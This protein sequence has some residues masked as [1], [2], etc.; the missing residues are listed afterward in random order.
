MKGIVSWKHSLHILWNVPIKTL[1]NNLMRL[2]REC[3]LKLC[4]RFV[5]SWVDPRLLICSLWKL[6]PCVTLFFSFCS[7]SVWQVFVARQM[8]EE[9]NETSQ[10]HV[11]KTKTPVH[12][13]TEAGREG[14]MQRKT[15]LNNEPT[16]SDLRG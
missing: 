5:V 8:E 3:P 16:H 11:L 13:I 15:Q 9:I 14:W 2:S 12:C 7:V 10:A 6:L 1:V 4:G